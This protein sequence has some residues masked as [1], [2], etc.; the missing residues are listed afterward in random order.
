MSVDRDLSTETVVYVRLL[1]EGTNVWRPVPAVPQADGS[2]RLDEPDDYD[3]QTESWEFPPH[4][5]VTCARRRF[6][7]GEEPLVAVAVAKEPARRGFRAGVG[8]G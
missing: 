6:A 5:K 7:D 2:F 1:D 3:P 4:T 8:K